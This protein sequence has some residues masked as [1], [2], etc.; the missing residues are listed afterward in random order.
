MQLTD[1]T[2][3]ILW[4]AAG[5]VAL[6]MLLPAVLNALGLTLRRSVIEDNPAAVEP[7]GDDAELHS[8]LAD[9]CALRACAF[10]RDARPIRTQSIA[11]G[12]IRE[13]TPLA[14]NFRTI[15]RFGSDR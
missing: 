14:P 6:W 10:R 7:T 3:T 4:L 2:L 12:E 13:Y 1:E 11:T 9:A 8:I 15:Q 5:A